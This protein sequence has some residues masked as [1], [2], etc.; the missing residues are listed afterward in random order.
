[1][2]MLIEKKT[3]FWP[4]ILSYVYLFRIYCKEYI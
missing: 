3:Q 2:E 4:K 1:M